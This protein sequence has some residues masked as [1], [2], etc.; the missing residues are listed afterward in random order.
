MAFVSHP[1][2]TQSRPAGEARPWPLPGARTR[3]AGA[4]ALSSPRTRARRAR[5]PAGAAAAAAAGVPRETALASR[6]MAWAPERQRC[7]CHPP[8]PGASGG[9]VQGGS[10]HRFAVRFSCIV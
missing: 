6:R 10:F 4:T 3:R 7:A 5:G 2:P 1:H 9:A 8:R